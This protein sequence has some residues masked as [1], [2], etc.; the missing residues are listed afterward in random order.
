MDIVDIDKVLDDLELNEDQNAKTIRNESSEPVP[1]KLE[2]FVKNN[3]AASTSQLGYQRP[4]LPLTNPIDDHLNETK[5][6][7]PPI[8]NRLPKTNFVNVS[9]VF[10][11]LNEYVNAVNEND[12]NV[13]RIEKLE[14]YTH[15]QLIST[16]TINSKLSEKDNT[17]SSIES[18]SAATGTIALNTDEFSNLNSSDEAILLISNRHR[19][20][21]V[22]LT[23]KLCETDS[24]SSSFESAEIE[25]K[26]KEINNFQLNN[27]EK[28]C[29]NSLEDPISI[30]NN[31]ATNSSSSIMP[32]TSQLSSNNDFSVIQPNS[33]SSVSNTIPVFTSDESLDNENNVLN[34]KMDEDNLEKQNVCVSGL[35]TEEMLYTDKYDDS[36]T[37][38]DIELDLNED[39]TN[40]E[41]KNVVVKLE[42]PE[43]NENAAKPESVL[44]NIGVECKSNDRFIKPICFEAAATM[45]DVSDTELESYLQELEDLEVLPN[46]SPD[47]I[48]CTNTASGSLSQKSA[49][50]SINVID[51]ETIEREEF[52]YSNEN[53][54]EIN[55]I[56]QKDDKNADSFSQ[57]STVE[58]ADING[59][60]DFQLTT[61]Y[62]TG[63]NNSN[64]NNISDIECSDN[65]N[66]V[67]LEAIQDSI[68]VNSAEQFKEDEDKASNDDGCKVLSNEQQSVV[69]EVTP[70][71]PNTLEL[72]ST[73]NTDP[74]TS[75]SIAGST[76]AN[77]PTSILL[78]CSSSD[79]SNIIATE[80]SA[81]SDDAIQSMDDSG[82]ELVASNEPLE[83]AMANNSN[84]AVATNISLTNL[85]KVQPYWIPDN[86]ALFCMQCNQKFSF[87]KRRHHC[88]ACG[89]VL[90]STC[91]SLKA[92]LEYMGEVETRIC[93]QCDILLNN[94]T[95]AT[96]DDCDTD[97]DDT[98]AGIDVASV[99]D[100]NAGFSIS[101]S[102]ARSPNPNNPMEYCSVI[103]PHQQIA[104]T[105]T[106]P[107]SVM[108][109][110]GVLKREGAPPKTARKEKNV[111]FSDGIRPGCD[112][113]ELDN[114]W[115]A[116]PNNDGN[117][118]FRKTGNRRAQ[119][120]PGNLH[121]SIRKLL[122]S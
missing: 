106:T 119:T 120:P 36:I 73:F 48:K 6:N 83:A 43:T 18:S 104:S 11:S 53:D 7:T 28:G 39:T 65:Q 80:A 3:I 84:A 97:P 15:K 49:I 77:Q 13:L 35:D 9:N 41:I 32:A 110:V 12:T 22:P 111:M 63:N 85:G 76:P 38:D 40:N 100:T 44:T 112:L 37:S 92:K 122:F 21:A 57:A 19:I 1:N 27:T 118:N 16:N 96:N 117:G 115:G 61:T 108:V 56:I 71:R 70:K 52:Y 14:D 103:P 75:N 86:M 81:H 54:S 101:N 46:G 67:N 23:E 51:P 17:S 98:A 31:T 109:P 42:N 91:C 99:I 82:G 64:N 62:T 79:E 121:I 93:I 30:T 55:P 10:L 68:T 60:S 45:D 5:S 116:R 114:N 90:C 88:R 25:L 102:T 29:S 59:D 50:E 94:R 4:L 2:K 66:D 95:N 34:E 8:P 78:S 24:T 74:I 72:S 47:V 89:Q 105:S 33:T 20:Q 26:T 107:I 69:L 58:F 113:T 87:I